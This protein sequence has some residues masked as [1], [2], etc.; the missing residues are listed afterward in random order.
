MTHEAFVTA[1]QAGRLIVRVDPVA[2]ARLVA[3]RMLLPWI[4]LAVAGCAVALA[5]SGHLL[6]G[7]LTLAVAIIARRLVATSSAGYVLQRAIANPHFFAEAL[8]AGVLQIDE[9]SKSVTAEGSY[10]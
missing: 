5:L 9:N 7:A 2:A 10:T 8:A 1:L 4:L 3:A 6:S